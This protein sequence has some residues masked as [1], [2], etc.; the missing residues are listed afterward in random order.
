MA[1]P[2]PSP[3]PNWPL[4][5]L[6]KNIGVTE[7]ELR[8]VLRDGAAE[9]ERLIP[10]LIEQ[11]TTGG[12][13]K[14]AQSAIVLREIRAL[15]A[16]LWGDVGPVVRKGVVRTVMTAAE[17]EDILFKFLGTKATQLMKA[18]LREQAKAGVEAVLAKSY[19]GI[20]L[21]TQVYRTQA[22][23]TGLVHKRV[24]NGLILGHSAK[25]IAKDVR[26]LISPDVAGGVSYAAMRLA[27][28]EINNAYKTSQEW[29]YK[30][31]P[32][33]R[34]MRWNL[35]R[36]HPVP[37]VCNHYAE[38]DTGLGPG[39][40]AFGERPLSHPNCLCYLTP[41]QATEDEFIEGFLAGEYDDYLD[42]TLDADSATAKGD[43]A[44]ASFA[45]PAAPSQARRDALTGDAAMDSVPK[46][47]FK[48][49]TLTGPQHQALATYET[50]YFR[51][52]NGSLRSGEVAP[53]DQRMIDKIDSAM[54]ESV[55]PED[56]IVWRGM[57]TARQLFQDSFDGDLTGFEWRELG[58]S[59]TTTEE[60]RARDFMVLSRPQRG[61]VKLRVRVPAG[62][63]AV[64]L[65]TNTEGSRY[66]GPQ[67]EVTLQRN[68]TWRIVKDHGV[69]P[70][71][72]RVLEAEVIL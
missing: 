29:R 22:L 66:N 5:A 58:Y 49:G 52:I 51:Q 8:S 6:L 62:T 56:V 3:P 40:Y 28:T 55:L 14:A 50:S 44:P 32:W 7:K 16:A 67:A 59:S 45:P 25:R 43:I 4:Q 46:G 33:S 72:Y 11:Q 18:A 71:G 15:M 26:D 24:S 48:K 38:E 30:D 17:G 36:S 47:L 37:D 13:L 39:V 34:G 68:V 54:D 2:L 20:P 61:N 65:S 9:A 57:Y 35:S 10:K 21:S 60:S 70:D 64:Q 19:N 23:S 69:H 12:K 41:E 53:V 63:K 31:E 27:R 42:E 1:Q